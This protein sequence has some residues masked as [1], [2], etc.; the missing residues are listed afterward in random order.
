[1]I[2]SKPTEWILPLYSRNGTCRYGELR[3][4]VNVMVVSEKVEKIKK[5]YL[6][7]DEDPKEQLKKLNKNN[8]MN[9]N[10]TSELQGVVKEQGLQQM[11]GN[12]DT[13]VYGLD[14]KCQVTL[15]MK[16]MKISDQEK[17]KIKLGELE[18]K[19]KEMVEVEKEFEIAVEQKKLNVAELHEDYER[20]IHE[21]EQVGT[22]K[23]H[24][25]KKI[26]ESYQNLVGEVVEDVTTIQESVG[27]QKMVRQYLFK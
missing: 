23:Q 18:Q 8:L 25:E 9:Y 26:K 27:I 7:T 6:M 2:K 21:L 17:Y 22:L 15:E 19:H 5:Q 20:K 3:V 14:E 4:C 11:E 1:M 10:F 16:Q 13:D 24:D 12:E